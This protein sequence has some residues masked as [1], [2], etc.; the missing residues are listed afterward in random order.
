M[1]FP[2]TFVSAIFSPK[3]IQYLSFFE[4]LPIC[5]LIPHEIFQ[6]IYI[7]LPERVR[8]QTYLWEDDLA[9]SDDLPLPNIRNT[10]KDTFQ[11]LS[12]MNQKA[13]MVRYMAKQNPFQTVYFAWIDIDAPRYFRTCSETFQ[14]LAEHFSV[15]KSEKEKTLPEHS[16]LYI[17]GCWS[18]ITTQNVHSVHWRF[19][20]SF[21][22]GTKKG[23]DEFATLYDMYW[24]SFLEEFKTL[25]WEVNFWAWLEETGKL[26]PRWYAADHNDTLVHLPKIYKYQ[27]LKDIAPDYTVSFYEYPNLS[28]YHPMSVSF[29]E[30]EGRPLINTRF[31]NYWIRENGSYWYP[32]DEGVIRTKNI[33][34]TLDEKGFPIEFQEMSIETSIIPKTNVFSEGLED[35]RLYNS[36]ETGTLKCIG[37]SLQYSNCDKIRMLIA[38]YNINTRTI[39]DLKRIIPPKDTWCE[40]NW[41]PI[42]LPNGK[43]G[44]IYSWHPLQIGRIIT[45]SEEDVGQLE[46]IYTHETP[47]HFR[48]RKGSTPFQLYNGRYVGIIHFSEETTP[49][50]YFHQMIQLDPNTYQMIEYSPIFCYE[51]V[52]IEFCMGFRILEDMIEM[53]ISQ[54]DRDP[55]KIKVK[56]ELF[57][58]SDSKI[59]SYNP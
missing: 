49:R 56:R 57:L 59:F 18:N 19:C 51:K 10:E 6:E 43:D 16:E 20:G 4:K 39:H 48:N 36:Q 13:N 29:V 34:S 45:T 47:N 7:L 14:Y 21:F 17:P 44:F 2:T 28:P 24:S 22:W 26:K 46:I 32:E 5:L 52:G 53:W 35:I 54:M 1:S 30:M 55:I 25:T 12:N 9:I 8:L 38:E 41:A 37:S 42:P 58:D 15:N 23:I 33:V 3:D 50:Q 11:H 27:I 40:K 31:V